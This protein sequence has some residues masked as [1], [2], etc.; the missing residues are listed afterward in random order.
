MKINLNTVFKLLATMLVISLLIL[1]CSCGAR[2]SEKTNKS[3]ISK[4]ETTD[5]SRNDKSILENSNIKSSEKITINNQDQT[6]TIEEIIEPLDILKP[7]TYIDVFGKTE[8]FNNA[9]K[10]TKTTVKNNNTKSDQ[11]S[12]KE[13]GTNSVQKENQ[14]NDVKKAAQTKKNEIKKN[15]D[16]EAWSIWNFAW[17]LLLVPVC[18][19]WKY[20]GKI[21]EKIW[22]L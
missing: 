6:I 22:W 10:T 7:A 16:R 8:Q 5:L 2:K 1:V 13:I 19:L 14:Q 15:I 4:I 9:K 17:L 20:W 11:E 12:K 18:L 3:V 21:K